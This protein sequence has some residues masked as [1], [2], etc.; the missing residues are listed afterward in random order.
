MS[1]KSNNIETIYPGLR[2]YS[3][4]E[5]DIFFGREDQLYSLIEQLSF[6]RY[7][8]VVGNSGCGK[9]SLVNEGLIPA[10]EKGSLVHQG[11]KW[12]YAYLHPGSQPLKELTK[13]LLKDTAIG[14][15]RA[16]FKNNEMFLLANLKRNSFGLIDAIDETPLDINTNLGLI[17]D[18][19]EEIFRSKHIAD[20]NEVSSFVYLLIET[21]KQTKYPIYVVIT[22]R[23][24]FI[25]E[26]SAF[27]HLSEIVAKNLFLTPRLTIKQLRDIIIK[28]AEIKK[29]TVESMLVSKLIN[30][31][32]S[33]QDQLPILQHILMRM[34][35]K[36]ASKSKK[37]TFQDYEE[38]GPLEDGLSKHANSIYDDLNVEQKEI[39][40]KLFKCLID[41]TNKHRDMRK[42]ITL[43]EA[44]NIINIKPVKLEEIVVKFSSEHCN[45]LTYSK[46]DEVID[47][48]HESLIRQW[49]RL[50][51]WAEQEKD[52][53]ITYFDLKKNINSAKKEKRK[54]QSYLNG[55][56]LEKALDWKNNTKPNEYWASRHEE[57][58]SNIKE[59]SKLLNEINVFIIES[60]ENEKLK[61]KK[62]QEQEQ[63]KIRQKRNIQLISFITIIILISALWINSEKN[64]QI[65]NL[66]ESYLTHS[67]LQ[68]Q[69][70][71]Y[72]ETQKILNKSKKLDKNILSGRIRARN[73]IQW[74][75]QFLSDKAID[76]HKIQIDKQINI[77]AV[78]NDEPLLI[79]G[80]IDGNIIL[81]D[82]L[83]HRLIDCI[84]GEHKTLITSISMND[85]KKMFVSAD[86]NGLIIF[87]SYQRKKLWQ[88]DTIKDQIYSENQIS[89]IEINKTNE[90]SKEYTKA[91]ILLSDTNKFHMKLSPDGENIAYGFNSIIIRKV[92]ENGELVTKQPL[93]PQYSINNIAFSPNS[94]LLAV[95]SY[96]EIYLWDKNNFDFKLLYRDTSDIISIC[97]LPKQ[98]LLSAA[99]SET[100]HLIDYLVEKPRYDI[101]GIGSEISF[102]GIDKYGN[103]IIVTS[104]RKIVVKSLKNEIIKI[105]QGHNY[106]IIGLNNTDKH[107]F[108]L[109]SDGIINQCNNLFNNEKFY[110]EIM[111][112]D[113]PKCLAIFLDGSKMVVGF[114][115]GTIQLRDLESLK[116]LWQNKDQYSIS[117]VL[118]NHNSKQ[119]VYFNNDN[120]F[121]ILDA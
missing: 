33:N 17:V 6:S 26:C 44:A 85:Q 109:D 116:I 93:Y 36:Y 43:E 59:I 48:S 98:N 32:E 61:E 49:D 62:R 115:G 94:K 52:A 65:T 57:N 91:T 74:Y 63:E 4:D 45:F 38:I 75:T 112:N 27:Y 58:K 81:Y 30:D 2:A 18:Q 77:F 102:T 39:T 71:N 1:N 64:T 118:F 13:A 19:F 67:S 96:S 60:E 41:N 14:K 37:F 54:K 53:V 40:K 101:S 21:A 70:N 56:I 121:T 8:A 84:K 107:I 35:T 106:S 66:F 28:P 55:F 20:N 83:K 111:L 5:K 100:I 68:I 73:I 3:K 10:F 99:T 50:I 120:N 108:T 119:V 69:M 11:D 114:T 80:T 29:A 105:L 89:D 23:S 110:K 86:N 9:S 7:I 72:E 12:K 103:I 15:E 42:S 97:F 113:E 78:S 82:L 95:A 117:K 90:E 22:M 51:K 104:D 92:N 87:W 79:A 34:W 16:N 25:G 88:W 46:I 47:I 31:M 76:T 24:D